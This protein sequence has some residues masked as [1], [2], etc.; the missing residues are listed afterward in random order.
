M[1]V[2]HLAKSST[3]SLLL[4]NVRLVFD[5]RW[6]NVRRRSGGNDGGVALDEIASRARAAAYSHENVG[7][8]AAASTASPSERQAQGEAAMRAQ[9]Q[10]LTLLPAA[11]PA[12]AAPPDG[13]ADGMQNDLDEILEQIEARKNKG[14]NP[15][16]G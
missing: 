5:G 12:A 7:L 4:I 16:R 3:S 11:A 8:R 15:P 2:L 9:I 10:N 13:Q 6:A 14:S 1:S